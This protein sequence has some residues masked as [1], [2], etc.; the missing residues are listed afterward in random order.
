V[1]LTC[2]PH[3]RHADYP[4]L[5]NHFPAVASG[6][7]CGGRFIV[8]A[9]FPLRPAKGG[10]FGKQFSRTVAATSGTPSAGGTSFPIGREHFRPAVIEYFSKGAA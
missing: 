6:E 1:T 9:D 5:S 3:S 7:L 8:A 10:R 4:L 2:S